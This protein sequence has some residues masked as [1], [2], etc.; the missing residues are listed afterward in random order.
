MIEPAH[1]RLHSAG[2][3]IEE[4]LN[5]KDDMAAMTIYQN[6]LVP[7]L[8]REQGYIDWFKARV[9]ENIRDEAHARRMVVT[10]VLPGLNKLNK[11]LAHVTQ[12]SANTILMAKQTI[13]QDPP[14]I[15]QNN[16]VLV[17][18]RYARLTPGLPPRRT[19]PMPHPDRVVI[20]RNVWMVE[21]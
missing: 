14:V 17:G 19:K 7:A 8:K 12:V 9:D 20:L 21:V 18:N 16:F 10:E 3:K 1:F 5:Q 6:Q 15:D 13:T 4:A 2:K 11:L